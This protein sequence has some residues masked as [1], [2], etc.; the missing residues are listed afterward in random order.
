MNR[1][2]ADLH[3]HTLLSPCGDIEMR[4]DSSEKGL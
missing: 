1:F 4:A 3:N 2:R